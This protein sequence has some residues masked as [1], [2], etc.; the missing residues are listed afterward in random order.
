MRLMTK[1][2]YRYEDAA[3]GLEDGA[4]FSLANG[5]NPDVLLLIESR[6]TGGTAA[7]TWHYG[8][9][10]MGGAVLVVNLDNQQVWRE[11]KAIPVPAVRPTYMNRKFPRT[12]AP[13]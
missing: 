10:R 6:K 11:E 5:T 7:P 2:I 13:R 4:I 12:A 8:V 9:A 3:A 1:P